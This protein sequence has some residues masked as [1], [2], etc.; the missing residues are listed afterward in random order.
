L[1]RDFELWEKAGSGFDIHLRELFDSF[2]ICNRDHDRDQKPF[3]K[4]RD[5]ILIRKSISDFEIKIDP[6]LKS[7]SPTKSTDGR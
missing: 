2:R 1:D 6:R 3:R 7:S 4:N 5:P